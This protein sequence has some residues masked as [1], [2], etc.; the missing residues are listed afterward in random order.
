MVAINPTKQACEALLKLA[1]LIS[2]ARS[3]ADER[4]RETHERFNVFTTL[5][6]AGDEVRLHTRFI[7]CLL[8][9]EGSHDCGRLFL[10][11]FLETLREHPGLGHDDSPAALGAPCGEVEWS[12]EKEA[13]RGNHGQIDLLLETQGFGIAIENKIHAGEQPEQLARYSRYLRSRYEAGA[14]VI[15]LTLDGKQSSTHEQTPYIRISYANHV[16]AWLE[17]CLKE[18]RSI[19]PIHQ[20]LLQYREVVRHITGQT[21]DSSLMKTVTEFILSNPEIIRHR[22]EIEKGFDDA[23]AVIMQRL[24]EAIMNGLGEGFQVR[25]RADIQPGQFGS[26]PIGALIISPP[27]GSPLHDAPFE[28]W[29][30]HIS[31][32]L[33]LMVGIEARFGK[34]PLNDETQKQLQ[35]MNQLLDE[36]SRSTG[37]H[38]ATIT[39]PKDGT[40]W[41]TGWHNLIYPLDEERLATMLETPI[42]Q[43]GATVCAQI[44]THIALLEKVFREASSSSVQ[45]NTL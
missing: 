3:R 35:R 39:D 34:G 38:K 2:E 15:Y 11:L 16:T 44:R 45:A 19:I 4:A 26:H 18:T 7:H 37:Y 42:D 29:V 27:A 20:V 8:N 10:D 40:L 12:V 31:K 6:G 13:F 24:A 28:I 1:K 36:H 41:P 9:P 14:R 17:K 32:W 30:E 43:T 22:H 21:L 23:R 33:S 25:L 5:L